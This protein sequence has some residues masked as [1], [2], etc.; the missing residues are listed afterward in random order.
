MTERVGAKTKRFN[1][2][3]TTSQL[4]AGRIGVPDNEK[5]R[6][7]VGP[8]CVLKNPQQKIKKTYSSNLTKMMDKT[9]ILA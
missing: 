4:Y 7:E 2:T 1:E 5:Q 3:T 6:K 9:Q 8:Y